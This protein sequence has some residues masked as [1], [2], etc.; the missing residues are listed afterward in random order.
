HRLPQVSEVCQLTFPVDELAP[1]FLLQLY[2]C[3]NLRKDRQKLGWAA[4]SRV[5]GADIRVL[6][7]PVSAY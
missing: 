7:D 3:A 5:I 2:A 4:A 1:E 6:H